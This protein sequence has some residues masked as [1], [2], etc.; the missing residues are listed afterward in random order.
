MDELLTQLLSLLKGIWKYRWY[1][2]VVAWLVMIGGWYGVYSMPDNYQASA[3]VYVD[4]QSILKPI[5]SGM[6]TIPDVEQ[7]VSI[8]SRTLLSRPNIERVMRMVDLDIKAQSAKEKDALINGLMSQIRISGTSSH[9]IY[10]ISYNNKDPG[11][12]KN[13]VQS[14]LTIFIEGSIGDKRKDSDNAVR[15]IDEQIKQYEEKLVAAE[16]AVKEFKL[17]NS[18]F[19]AGREGD[20]GAK[21]AESADLLNQ[22][23]LQLTEAEQA[24]N[25]IKR[26]IAGEEPM[27]GGEGTTQAEAAV[28]ADP[29]LEARIQ[30]MNKSLDS[31]RLQYTEEHPDV[32]ATKRLL[33]QLDA[34]KAEEAKKRAQN[35]VTPGTIG[36][37]YAPVL[38]QLKVALSDAEA[39]V[40]AMKARADEYATRYERLKAKSSAVPEVEA[41]LS[42]LN[43]DY[44]I[45][46]ANYEKLIAGRESA[47]LSGNLSTNSEMMTFRIIDPPTVPSTPSGPNRPRL[48]ALAFLFALLSGIGVALLI[49]QVRP[50]FVSH[51]QLREITGFPVL[52]TVSMKWTDQEKR[53]RTRG[54]FA[55][56]SSFAGLLLVFGGAMTMMSGLL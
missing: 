33:A 40:A 53:R 36:K 32:I 10:A 1:S 21:L 9:D 7:Q 31:L 30:G 43:R 13:V 20:Y 41:Q 54:M 56:G 8:M 35:P 45:N 34:R 27:L 38:Q 47:K 25:S 11:L 48:F 23:R 12:A 49:S 42:Q 14:L 16:N 19:L 24:R 39:R 5:L 55:F 15:F 37:N 2:M 22:A 52:G 17:K 50:T 4:T 44:Q 26:E 28:A 46:K 6:T 29:E 51:A 18:G 3:R